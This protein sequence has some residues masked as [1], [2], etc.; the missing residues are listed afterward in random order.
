MPG[1]ARV[2][3]LPDNPSAAAFMRA[4]GVKLPNPTNLRIVYYPDPILTKVA[5][6]VTDFGPALAAL[7]DRM[8]MLM[9]EGRGVGLAAPQVGL[10]LR[11]FVC[12][13]SGE[14]GDDLVFVNPT[15][16]DLSGA[17]ER[18]EGC[19]SIPGVNVTMRRSAGASIDAFTCEGKPFRKQGEEIDARVWQHEID[20]FD[21]RLIT[22]N[23]ASTDEITNRRA[24][25][26]LEA[27]FAAVRRGGKA[28]RCASS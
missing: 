25:K 24:L 9:R 1:T 28:P 2:K 10:L 3:R 14:D 26:Q 6:P 11:L 20:H 4:E 17:S 7:A 23:M 15:L 16:S 8:L 13:V 22:D 19:L 27:D 18:E 21:G 5:Q 12:N